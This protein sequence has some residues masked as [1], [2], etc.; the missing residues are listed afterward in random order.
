[1]KLNTAA[2]NTCLDSGAKVGA[3]AK[4]VEEGRAAGVSGTPAMFINGRFLGG[5]QPYADIR[6]VIED[7]LQ[8]RAQT[9]EPGK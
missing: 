7:E 5:N 2:F 3:V 4:D 6:E 1:M 9:K 8:R